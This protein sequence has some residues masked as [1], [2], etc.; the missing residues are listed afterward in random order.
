MVLKRVENYLFTNKRYFMKNTFILGFVFFAFSSIIAQDY[1]YVTDRVFDGPES[2]FG[3]DFKPSVM[4]VPNESRD[5][6]DPGDYSFGVTVRNLYVEGEGIRGVYSMNN[7]G[8]TEYGYKI[9]T[10]NTRDARIQGHLKIILNRRGQ[11]NALIF[12]RSQKDPEIIFTL[13]EVDEDMNAAET[14]YFTDLREMEIENPDS[15]WGTTIYPFLR[16]HQESGI[17]ER[18]FDYDST[19]VN[20]EEVITIEE[21]VKKVKQP[22]K[23]K[24]RKS[25]E[26]E[27]EDLDIEEIVEEMPKDSVDVKRKI[28]KTYFLNIQQLIRYQDD[29]EKIETERYQITKVNEGEDETAKGNEDRFQIE[30]TTKKGIPVYLYLN[31]NR[32]VNSVEVGDKLYLMRGF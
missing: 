14:E 19:F 26:E 4:E 30:F 7:I 2:F 8:P 21:K 16:I 25:E 10:M 12:R 32:Q 29:T 22:K 9:A 23:K 24:K 15:I 3:Y 5:E 6:I 27:L 28:T 1:S 20:F 18:L 17:Q 31:E 13:P 11:V